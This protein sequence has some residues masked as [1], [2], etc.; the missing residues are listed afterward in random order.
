MVAVRECSEL[1]AGSGL[2][3][4]SYLQ[5][6]GRQLFYIV[7]GSYTL[8][9]MGSLFLIIACTVLALQFLTQMKRTR[10]RY[11][12]LGVLGAGREQ[13][14]GSLY[15]QVLWYFLLPLLLACASGA[16]GIYVMERYFFARLGDNPLMLIVAFAFIAVFVVIVALYAFTVARTAVRDLDRL[17]WSTQR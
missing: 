5:N 17:Q 13:M 6:Y 4:E 8:L 14:R 3:Y 7:A 12:T 2:Q 9:Y 16:V 1:L 10:R 15:R 11:L